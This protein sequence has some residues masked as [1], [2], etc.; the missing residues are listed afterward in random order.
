M[1]ARYDIVLKHFSV[2]WGSTDSPDKPGKYLGRPPSFHPG[3]QWPH[4]FSSLNADFFSI[5]ALGSV[6]QGWPTD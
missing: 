3:R 2:Q 6:A 5:N 1:A 4:I